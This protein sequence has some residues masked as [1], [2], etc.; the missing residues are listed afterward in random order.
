MLCCV[1]DG[2]GNP[3]KDAKLLEELDRRLED[4]VLNSVRRGDAVSRYGRGE[5]L[6]LLINT[7]G[8][9]CSRIQERINGR[10]LTGRQ[11]TGVRYYVNRV[12]GMPEQ[13]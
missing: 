8:E 12:I 3:V 7:T 5:Y 1:A 11:R 6:V 4:A 10:F 2:K 9:D 13:L